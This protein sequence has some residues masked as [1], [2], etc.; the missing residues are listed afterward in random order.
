MG[1]SMFE[2]LLL[3]SRK[4]SFTSFWRVG[5]HDPP[6]DAIGK[7]LPAQRGEIS[8]PKCLPIIFPPRSDPPSARISNGGAAIRIDLIFK[9][10]L[11]RR[12]DRVF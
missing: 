4:T 7:A 6:S 2:T 3:V 8:V 12:I 5:L 11:Q 1:G 10:T 9:H